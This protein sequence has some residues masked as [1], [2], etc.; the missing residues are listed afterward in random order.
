[1]I[2]DKIKTNEEA[3]SPS[4][5]NLVFHFKA[6]VNLQGG[7]HLRLAIPRVLNAGSGMF[8]SPRQETADGKQ[9][10]TLK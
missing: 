3:L 10:D 1:M 5:H 8:R 2:N 6:E 4:Q 9:T 7:P